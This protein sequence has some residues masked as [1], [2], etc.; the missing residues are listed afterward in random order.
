[1]FFISFAVQISPS[2]NDTKTSR[3]GNSNSKKTNQNGFTKMDKSIVTDSDGKMW[4]MVPPDGGWG[5]LI[6]VGAMLVNILIPGTVKT[7]GVLLVDFTEA[8]EATPAEV[9]WIPAL[10]YFLYS[11]LGPLSSILSVKYSFRTVTL[12]GGA[13][14]AAGMMITFWASSIVYLYLS[15]GVMVGIGAGLSFPPTVY[16]V[17]SY[18]VRLRGLANGLCISGSALGSIILPPVLRYLLETYGYRYDNNN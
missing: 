17:T 6:L 8:F 13:F 9:A 16:I 11:S 15:Y 7:F 1:M 14:A 2:T 18:F 4:K 10:C 12:L 3:N 5:W